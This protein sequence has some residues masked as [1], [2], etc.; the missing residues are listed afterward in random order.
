MD[1]TATL[2]R[3]TEWED[4]ITMA[5]GF[6]IAM[7]PWIAGEP[8]TATIELNAILI[9]FLIFAVAALEIMELQRWEEWLNLAAGGWTMAAPWALGYADHGTLMPLQLLLGALVALLAIVELWQ[10]RGRPLAAQ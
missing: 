6:L 2:S 5:F 8:H 7:S 4:W 9:G 10:D 3:H 1:T